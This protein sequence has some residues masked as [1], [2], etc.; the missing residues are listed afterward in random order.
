MM[1][2]RSRD[3]FNLFTSC[4][5]IIQY[6]N[7]LDIPNCCIEIGSDIEYVVIYDISNFALQLTDTR[8]GYTYS[9]ITIKTLK[10]VCLLQGLV[11]LCFVVVILSMCNE[12]SQCICLHIK[13]SVVIPPAST[14]L[15]GGYTGITLSVCSS[16]RLS[17]CGQNHVC[18]VSSTIFGGSISY[19][20][21]LSS[22]FC[23]N[24]HFKI[25]KFEIL[26]NFFNLLLWLCLL[27]TWDPIWLN[28]MG[29]HEAAE[30]ILRTQ[31]C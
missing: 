11:L 24:A 16:V 13:S 8:R 9:N 29:N 19:L 22:N 21:I 25:Q 5:S 28:G 4:P 10:V 7:H 18:S 26:A 31:A 2:I 17:V 12:F 1:G 30:G 3:R 15:K 20:H 14:K 6:Y 23:C 27:L